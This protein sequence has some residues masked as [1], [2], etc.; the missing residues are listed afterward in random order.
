MQFASPSDGSLASTGI[1]MVHAQFPLTPVKHY[2]GFM[3][4]LTREFG[5]LAVSECKRFLI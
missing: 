4:P 5:F 2:R 1:I 3:L